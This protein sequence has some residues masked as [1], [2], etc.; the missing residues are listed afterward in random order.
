MKYYQFTFPNNLGLKGEVIGENTD[1]RARVFME[2][3]EPEMTVFSKSV[4]GVI[5]PL[6]EAVNG[7]GYE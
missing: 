6:T 5:I 2:L 1:A 7:G 3:L 4:N